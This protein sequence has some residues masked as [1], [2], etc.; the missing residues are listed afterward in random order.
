MFDLSLTTRSTPSHRCIA[1]PDTGNPSGVIRDLPSNLTSRWVVKLSEEV[2]EI[3]QREHEE[4]L[5]AKGGLY[6]SREFVG[7]SGVLKSHP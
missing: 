2:H 1:P 6:P 7:L 4:E 3:D 5:M